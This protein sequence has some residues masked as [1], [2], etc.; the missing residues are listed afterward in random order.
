MCVCE[1]ELLDEVYIICRKCVSE[2]WVKAAHMPVS[3]SEGFFCHHYTL[4]FLPIWFTR[5]SVS[6]IHPLP[7]VVFQPPEIELARGGVGC[8]VWVGGVGEQRGPSVCCLILCLI[9]T[10]ELCSGVGLKGK[11]EM[12]CAHVCL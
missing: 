7:H 3:P 5:F 2:M 10:V 12:E 6:S 11:M 1:T 8:G 4:S 9:K